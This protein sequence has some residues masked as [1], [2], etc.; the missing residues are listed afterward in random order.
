M[1]SSNPMCSVGA[2]T[3]RPGSRRLSVVRVKPHLNYN[4]VSCMR[5]PVCFRTHYYRKRTIMCCGD[6]C[7]GCEAAST[8][9][10]GFL[11]VDARSRG[12][13]VGKHVVE[14]P[15]RALADIEN[16]EA[17]LRGG[18]ERDWLGLGFVLSRKKGARSPVVV[19]Q[20]E[21]VGGVEEVPVDKLFHAVC[22]MWQLPLPP[23]DLTNETLMDQWRHEVRRRVNS[24]HHYRL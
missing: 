20:V 7:P 3:V 19:S 9:E 10:V 17:L 8:R 4:L 1:M 5:D 2:A 18:P 24:E 15:I 11:V 6:G 12:E 21:R 23:Q 22:G 14:L 16:F 13:S